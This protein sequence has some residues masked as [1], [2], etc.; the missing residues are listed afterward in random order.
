MLIV[1]PRH[2]YDA[3]VDKLCILEFEDELS[4]SYL[5]HG[6][7]DEPDR[8]YLENSVQELIL[9]FQKFCEGCPIEDAL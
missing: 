7:N 8:E 2:R 3:A 9:K 4:V 6:A 1:S 5:K